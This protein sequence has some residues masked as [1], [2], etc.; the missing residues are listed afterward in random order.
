MPKRKYTL[1]AHGMSYTP[2]HQ[3]WRDMKHRC[4]NPNNPKYADYGGRGISY[5]PRWESFENFIADMGRRPPKH[6]LERRDND[7]NYRPDNCYWATRT[8]QLRN[9]RANRLITWN[10]KTQCLAAWAEELNLGRNCLHHRLKVGWP[11]ERMMTTPSKRDKMP[12]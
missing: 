12:V 5:D 11:V 3:A 10:G 6:S 2:E 8:T 7:G 9:T 1:W 4:T